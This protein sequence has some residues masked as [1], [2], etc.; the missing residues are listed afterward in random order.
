[1]TDLTLLAPP[2]DSDVFVI[3]DRLKQELCSRRRTLVEG[4]GHWANRWA[5]APSLENVIAVDGGYVALTSGGTFYNLSGQGDLALGGVREQW[6]KDRA[7]W[8]SELDA[9]AQ[10]HGSKSLALIGL[11]NFSGNER[12]C[13]WYVGNRLLLADLGSTTELRLLGATP[14]GEAAW[15]LDVASG[16]VYR[17][18]F[19]DPQKLDAAFGQGSQLL[20]AD[21]LPHPQREWSPWQFVELTADGVG[22]RGVTYEGVVVALRDQEPALITGVTQE[23]VVMQGG[24][25]IEGLRQLASQ[26]FHSPL[27]SVEEPGSLTWFVAES[28]RVIRVPKAA[29]PE[30]FEVLGTQQQTNILLHESQN[31]K[32]L[33]LPSMG[34]GGPL[35]YVQREGEVM[36]VEGHEAKIDDLLPL[37]PDDVKILILRMGQGAVS[38]RLSKAAWLRIKSVVLDCRHPLGSVVTVPGKLIWEL[39]EPDQLLL[40]KVHE[41]LVIIDPDSGHSVIFREVY[42]ADVNLRGD[43]LLSFGGHR[44]YAVST[45]VQRLDALQDAQN[46]VTLEALSNETSTEET[47]A[48]G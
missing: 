15:L 25:E 41:H 12:L 21:V 43:V 26:P 27:L 24:R 44:H 36:V 16:E 30:S 38:Y 31:G 8:W 35:S 32:L 28:A 48:V 17:Q 3:Y 47:N 4:K 22:L 5:R 39:E 46:G 29:I 14:D 10:R 13:A 37:M 45:L 20:E 40:S 34:H 7:Q 19:I 18:A 2:D 6:F 9:L 11:S 1:M 42:A 33:T 23:W